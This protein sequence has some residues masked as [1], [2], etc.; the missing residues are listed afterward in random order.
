MICQIKK[1]IQN[2]EQNIYYILISYFFYVIFVFV[3]NT[4]IVFRIHLCYIGSIV[5]NEYEY[6]Q[7][8][9]YNIEIFLICLTIYY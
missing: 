2:A 3:P 6:V 5:I 7:T 9:C 1:N 8:L 4:I